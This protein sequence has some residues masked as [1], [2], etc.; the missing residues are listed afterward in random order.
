[1]GTPRL[2]LGNVETT[3]SSPPSA[4]WDLQRDLPLETQTEPLPVCGGRRAHAHVGSPEHSCNYSSTLNAYYHEANGVPAKK[5]GEIPHQ[6]LRRE[7]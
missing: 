3:R 1:M 4:T 2:V 6:L 5:I 7:G